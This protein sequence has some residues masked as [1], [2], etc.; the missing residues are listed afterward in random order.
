[1][2]QATR[3]HQVPKVPQ[4]CPDDGLSGPF[5]PGWETAVASGRLSAVG[6]LTTGLAHELNNPLTVI[7][8]C[9]HLASET[10]PA[11][12]AAGEQL[13]AI[14]RAAHRCQ[15]LLRGLLDFASSPSEGPSRLD[16]G[17]VLGRALTLVS[18]VARHRSLELS[19]ELCARRSPVAG[20][21][22]ELQTALVHLCACVIDTAPAGGRVTVR[23]RVRAEEAEVLVTARGGAGAPPCR[24]AARPPVG[25]L[26]AL[27]I[28][29]KQGGSVRAVDGGL[30]LRLPLATRLA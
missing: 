19:T 20:R 30:L 9:A 2:R 24:G 14:A 5:G 1:M 27:E 28:F 6:R 11:G 15:S 16:L 18:P 8:G 10:L 29:R 4:G 21:R 17:E 25:L 26:L 23:S 13:R 3:R 12:H 22:E 7:L